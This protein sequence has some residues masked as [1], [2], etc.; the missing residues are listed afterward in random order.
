MTE[1]YRSKAGDGPVMLRMV[2]IGNNQSIK[3]YEAGEWRKPPRANY[4]IVMDGGQRTESSQHLDSEAKAL[5]AFGVLLRKYQKRIALHAL[6]VV[7]DAND[8]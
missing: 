7:V 1:R 4:W 6:G 2:E 3:L 8:G 5:I